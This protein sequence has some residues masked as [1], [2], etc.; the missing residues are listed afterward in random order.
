M[1]GYGQVKYLVGFRIGWGWGKQVER[2]T[3]ENGF[4]WFAELGSS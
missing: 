3:T 4:D 2:R 1:K